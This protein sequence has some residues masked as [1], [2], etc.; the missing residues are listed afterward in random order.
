MLSRNRVAAVALILTVLVAGCQVLSPEQ[1]KMLGAAVGGTV[2]AVIGNQIG[3]GT[4]QV[5]ATLVGAGIGTYLGYQLASYLSARQQAEV[6]STVEQQLNETDKEGSRKTLVFPGS[7][8]SVRVQTSPALERKNA[9]RVASRSGVQIQSERLA[10]LP[11]DT[12][13]RY[14]TN[15]V[16]V[17]NVAKAEQKTLY[18]RTSQGNWIPVGAKTLVASLNRPARIGG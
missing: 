8:K 1:K 12:V 10:K 7:N 18:C 16:S 6:K 15:V 17:E 2:G 11:K 3:S 14:N 9:V 13:C 5:V 4:G